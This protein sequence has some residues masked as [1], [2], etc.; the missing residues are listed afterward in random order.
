MENPCSKS[1]GDFEYEKTEAQRHEVTCLRLH[2]PEARSGIQGS[3]TRS[4]V[5]CSV[6]LGLGSGRREGWRQESLNYCSQSKPMKKTAVKKW[7]NYCSNTAG[8]ANSESKAFDYQL[9]W[10][11]F[12]GPP[13]VAA[14]D[15]VHWHHGFQRLLFCG[16][17][18]PF[19]HLKLPAPVLAS[20]CFWTTEKKVHTG[21]TSPQSIKIPPNWKV[22]WPPPSAAESSSLF[23]HQADYSA[24]ELKRTRRI[25]GFWCLSPL[26]PPSK[27]HFV[28]KSW[29]ALSYF[30]WHVTFRGCILFY[31]VI[32]KST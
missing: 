14:S 7:R 23:F 4:S 20:G 18:C 8:R 13:T 27:D 12:A 11:C 15:T 19:L 28:L 25:L 5:I 26:S 24:R 17:E 9:K 16:T 31:T 1:L 10:H 2:S 6:L 29:V 21:L 30:Y 22:T 32:F 3:T